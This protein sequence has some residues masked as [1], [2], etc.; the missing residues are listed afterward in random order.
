MLRNELEAGRQTEVEIA[1]ER[2]RLL[3]RRLSLR[4]CF[5]LVLSGFL[6]EVGSEQVRRDDGAERIEEVQNLNEDVLVRSKE[7]DHPG[8]ANAVDQ[9]AEETDEE[10]DRDED[11]EDERE[12]EGDGDDREEKGDETELQLSIPKIQSDGGCGWRG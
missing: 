8:I 9:R 6:H 12:R 4:R 5:G 1:C 11:P 7:F 3:V 10:V 2:D